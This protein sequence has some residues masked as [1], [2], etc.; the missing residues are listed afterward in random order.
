MSR[1]A[2]IHTLKPPT[3]RTYF[4]KGGGCERGIF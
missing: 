4:I 3:P 1:T 2:V